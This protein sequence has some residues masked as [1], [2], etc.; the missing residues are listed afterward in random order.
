MFP[1]N[2]VYSL[3]HALS[4]T[5]GHFHFL[6]LSAEAV[7]NTYSLRLTAHSHLHRVE[8]ARPDTFLVMSQD[9]RRVSAHQIPGSHS[10]ISRPSHH[11]RLSRLGGDAVHCASMA[12]QHHHLRLR[13]NVPD[14]TDTVSSSGEQDVQCGMGGDA[15]HAAEMPVVGAH[16]LLSTHRSSPTRLYSRSQH[17]TDLSSPQEKRYGERADTTTPRTVCEWPVSVSFRF[18]DARSQIYSSPPPADTLIVRSAEPVTNHSLLTSI[19][20]QRTQPRW[21]AITRAS[22]QG[23]CH[24]GTGAFS[25]RVRR[26]SADDYG[27]LDPSRIR[28][29]TPCALPSACTPRCLCST[30]LS[31]RTNNTTSADAP[32]PLLTS[33]PSRLYSLLA[34]CE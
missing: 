5:L 20:T 26:T 15:V 6:M 23:A 17:F 18:P 16:H 14:A 34:Q 32:S 3:H 28:C 33:L 8:Q 30:C 9:R 10:G 29:A 19:D 24:S 22:F 2:S 4:H 31:H 12:S 7:A 13:A 1:R 27:Q 11:L 25:S 21:P